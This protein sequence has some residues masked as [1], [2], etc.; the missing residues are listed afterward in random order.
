MNPHFV[1]LL[2]G[3]HNRRLGSDTSASA[4][5]VAR[6]NG[7]DVTAAQLDKQVQRS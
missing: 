7:K 6:I 1:A 5:V 4:N 2:A 3:L